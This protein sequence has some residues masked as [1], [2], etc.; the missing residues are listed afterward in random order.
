MLNMTRD[1]GSLLGQAA[2][3]GF[4]LMS[5]AALTRHLAPCGEAALCSH[6]PSSGPFGGEPHG[7]ARSAWTCPDH[8]RS[9]HT[10]RLHVPCRK[11]C[12]VGWS[13]L[14]PCPRSPWN[15]GSPRPVSAGP[16]PLSKMTALGS[17]PQQPSEPYLL[18][19]CHGLATVLVIDA[20]NSFSHPTPNPGDQLWFPF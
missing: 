8:P 19:P 2:S 1:P 13:L 10:P 20:N 6:P 12:V 3:L 18:R 16:A 11:A 4:V 7:M 14:A 5:R 17:S 9:D 15:L